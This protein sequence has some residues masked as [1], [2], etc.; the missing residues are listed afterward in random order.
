[1]SEELKDNEKH[2]DESAKADA[3]MPQFKDDPNQGNLINTMVTL[4]KSHAGYP[5]AS[6]SRITNVPKDARTW[7]AALS[8]IMLVSLAKGLKDQAEFEKKFVNNDIA[9]VQLHSAI[10]SLAADGCYDHRNP[11]GFVK[12]IIVSGFFMLSNPDIFE[13]MIICRAPGHA[14]SE[15]G[16]NGTLGLIKG[17]PY[18]QISTAEV[19]EAVK[20]T[21]PEANEAQADPKTV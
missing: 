6:I 10:P 18:H 12:S 4:L 3:E 19:A 2:V 11:N 21:Q 15:L 9:I 17:D 20:A 8:Q 5:Y 1:M 7:S 16:Q 14:A 13:P